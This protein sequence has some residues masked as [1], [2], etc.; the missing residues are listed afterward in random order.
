[1]A[2]PLWP[3]LLPPLRPLV[4]SHAMN[5]RLPMNSR[6]LSKALPHCFSP[7]QPPA[8][9]LSALL[10]GPVKALRTSPRGLHG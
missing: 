5:A 9:G 10:L 8:S 6:E 2:G 1:M 7:Q 4:R 3:L